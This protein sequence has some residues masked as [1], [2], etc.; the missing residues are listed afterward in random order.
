MTETPA[1]VPVSPDAAA[2][3]EHSIAANAVYLAGPKRIQGTPFWTEAVEVLRQRFAKHHLIVAGDGT[4]R[5]YKPVPIRELKALVPRLV[6][7]TGGAAVSMRCIR[8]TT[9]RCSW[10]TDV[11]RVPERCS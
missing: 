10:A 1:C 5:R 4:F 11:R 2:P 9:S 3:A 7:P 6:S 8:I